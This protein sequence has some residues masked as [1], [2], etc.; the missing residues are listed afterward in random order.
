VLMEQ[1]KIKATGQ[2]VGSYESM[3]AG[4]GDVN[5]SLIRSC[6]DPD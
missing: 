6:W 2:S 4:T 1:N 5:F 3:V